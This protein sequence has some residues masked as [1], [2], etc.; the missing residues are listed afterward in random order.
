MLIRV[1]VIDANIDQVTV[2]QW[3]VQEGDAV[4][5]GQPVAEMMTEKATF[6]LESECTGT[7][8]KIFA[9]EGSSVPS[10]YILAVLRYGEEIPD[11]DS[12]D[13]QNEQIMQEHQK[14]A[15]GEDVG[16][17]VVRSKVRAT[18]GAR[19]LA[20]EKNIQ[21]QDISES[22]GKRMIREK[23]VQDFLQGRE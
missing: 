9:S 19:T 5:K 2:V 14:K 7:V 1:P 21:L 4:D 16:N 6:E 17:I 8:N 10:G 12:I 3:L 15:T 22:S 11:T 20:K 13:R 23:D 18:P